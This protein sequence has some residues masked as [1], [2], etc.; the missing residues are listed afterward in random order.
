MTDY[1]LCVDFTRMGDD[2][3]LRTRQRNAQP[4]SSRS[5]EAM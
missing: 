4:A 2:R 1:D 5:S 3:R